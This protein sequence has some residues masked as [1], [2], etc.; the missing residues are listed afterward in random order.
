MRYSRENMFMDMARAASKRSTCSRLNVGALVVQ[1]HN[2]ISFGY[3]GAPSGAPHCAGNDCPGMTPGMCPALH[4]EHNALMKA[5]MLVEGEVELYTT[6]SPCGDCTLLIRNHGLLVRRIFF[7]IPY[8]NTEHLNTFRQIYKCED[9]TGLFRT[10]EVYEVTPA[11]YIVEYFSR[12]V[13]ELP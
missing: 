7:E 12:R 8:R 11:G 1:N 3:N 13:V 4:A 5:Q 10:T 2:V 9:G 6:H